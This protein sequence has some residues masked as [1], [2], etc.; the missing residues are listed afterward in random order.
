ME[1]PTEWLIQDYIQREGGTKE[2]RV[3]WGQ[4]SSVIEIEC[5]LRN[6]QHKKLYHSGHWQKTCDI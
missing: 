5:L 6:Q 4:K 1:K 3:S 2:Y